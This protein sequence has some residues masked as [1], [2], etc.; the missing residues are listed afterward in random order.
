MLLKFRADMAVE[1]AGEN[2][3]L[4]TT[5][6]FFGYDYPSFGL[7]YGTTTADSRDWAAETRPMLNTTYEIGTTT[8]YL[9]GTFDISGRATLYN[10]NTSASYSSDITLV[11][12]SYIGGFVRKESGDRQKGLV[13]RRLLKS[14]SVKVSSGEEEI[15]LEHKMITFSV[16]GPSYGAIF[17]N[18]QSS[19]GIETDANGIASVKFTLGTATGTYKVKATCPDDVCTSWAKEVTF[20][21]TAKGTKLVGVNSTWYG[22]TSRR[23]ANPFRFKVVDEVTGEPVEGSTVTYEVIRFTSPGGNT[24]SNVHGAT[25]QGAQ[26]FTTVTDPFGMSSAAMDMGSEPGT[27][28]VRVQCESCVAGQEESGSGIVQTYDVTPEVEKV[29]AGDPAVSEDDCPSGCCPRTPVLQITG[30]AQADGNTSFTSDDSENTLDLHARVLPTCLLSQ[31]GITWQVADAPGDYIESL[32][33]GAVVTPPAGAE[34]SFQV[35]P[36][37]LP[38]ADSGR[39][40]PLAYK[41]TAGVS[42][43]GEMLYTSK[44]VRQDEIDKCRQEYLDYSVSRFNEVPRS[45]F[46][47]G[48]HPQYSQDIKDCYAYIYPRK[49]MG[50]VDALLAAG[51]TLRVTSGYRSPRANHL[52]PGIGATVESTRNST[53]IFGQAVDMRPINSGDPSAWQE[54]WEADSATCPKSLE[55]SPTQ[56]MKLCNGTSTTPYNGSFYPGSYEAMFPV[57]TC[58]HI[59]N[60]SK[61]YE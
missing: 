27:Y 60:S 44:I 3:D 54:L 48:M 5:F 57:A 50:K 14:F 58:I 34:S 33:S 15:P 53:H 24:G 39:P 2:M 23:L 32:K 41:V 36:E 51:Y 12:A 11:N 26:V 52:L 19:M 9:L 28:V 18:G 30:I 43:F 7:G 17:P 21:A 22:R 31:G 8:Y 20:T 55:R 10:P 46:T 59:G 47:I 61:L 40:L 16:V 42:K 35:L 25:M 37:N 1:W 29:L 13:T 6:N 38:K 4:Q 56:V 49:E 45:A